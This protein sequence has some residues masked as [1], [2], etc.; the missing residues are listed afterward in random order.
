MNF[1]FF[2]SVLTS[3]LPRARS[4]SADSRAADKNSNTGILPLSVNV[5]IKDF[6]CI[7][8]K[9]KKTQNLLIN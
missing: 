3:P 6:S 4:Y 7:D 2:F 1:F 8:L 5:V 9:K